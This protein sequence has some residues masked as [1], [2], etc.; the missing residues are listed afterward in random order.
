MT[1]PEEI[2]DDDVGAGDPI[3]A[4]PTANPSRVRV[5]PEGLKQHTPN[6]GEPASGPPPGEEA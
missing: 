4:T 5:P 1:E 3:E 6:E 2:P